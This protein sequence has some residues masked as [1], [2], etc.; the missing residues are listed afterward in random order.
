MITITVMITGIS[1]IVATMQSDNENKND[2]SNDSRKANMN[3]GK[4]LLQTDSGKHI[5]SPYKKVICKFSTVYLAVQCMR[6][7]TCWPT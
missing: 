2:N 7:S 4:G 1:K 3:S 5:E 6:S